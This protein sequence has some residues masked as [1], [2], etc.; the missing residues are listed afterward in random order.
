MQDVYPFYDWTIKPLLLLLLINWLIATIYIRLKYF[1]L[2]ISILYVYQRV[3]KKHR[4]IHNCSMQES[5]L[6][7]RDLLLY[8]IIQWLIKTTTWGKHLHQPALNVNLSVYENACYKGN[9]L[10]NTTPYKVHQFHCL[11]RETSLM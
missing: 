5:I 3:S 9:P 7:K 2:S 4:P 11:Y 1:S 10:S 6:C 8:R